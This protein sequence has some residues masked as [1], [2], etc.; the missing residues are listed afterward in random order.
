M[1]ENYE[2]AAMKSGGISLNRAMRVLIYCTSIMSLIAFYL[3]IILF[4]KH[5][6]VL[7]T[8]A[9]PFCKLH[10]LWLS[11]RDSLIK[12]AQ[13]SILRLKKNLAKKTGSFRRCNVAC[14]EKEYA[15]V[16][17]VIKAKKGV[18]KSDKSTNLL[19]LDLFDGHYYEDVPPQNY[20]DRERYPFAKSSFKKYTI[21][22]DLATLNSASQDGGEIVNAHN[23][24]SMRELKYTIDSLET[25]YNKDIV[26][27]S[28]NLDQKATPYY[29][30]LP[31]EALPKVV[32]K[33]DVY[34]KDLL[35]VFSPDRQATLREQAKGLV[36][37]A[38]FSLD[39]YQFDLTVKRIT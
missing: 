12:L 19:Q 14:K 24:L 28:E 7:L 3:Q 34:S 6:T 2:F 1:A 15:P 23:M 10:L 11:V 32:N 5:N 21:N 17:T 29:N 8:C 30:Y 25:N 9:K 16:T 33:V 37:N 22:I 13:L 27:F 39:G 31:P 36:S 26:S 35:S 18:L 38:V 20:E 4:Q